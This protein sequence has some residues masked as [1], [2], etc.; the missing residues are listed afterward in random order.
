MMVIQSSARYTLAK[1]ALEDMIRELPRPDGSSPNK[2]PAEEELCRRLGVS[3]ATVREALRMLEREGIIS[4][5]HGSGNYYHS[6]ALDLSMRIDTIIDFTELLKDG[7]YQVEQRCA[8]Q[9][10]RPASPEERGMF[11]LQGEFLTYDWL[12]LAN[13]EVAILTTNLVPP[14]LMPR[15]NQNRNHSGHVDSNVMQLIWRLTGETVAHANVAIQARLADKKEREAFGLK[16]PAPIMGWNQIF[17]SFRDLP[18]AYVKVAF[19]PRIVRMQ[20]LQKWS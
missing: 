8:E 17:Y 15:E 9:C 16:A 7:G 13:G 4:K 11:K 20:M 18:V 5:R 1:K 14:D 19:N 6:S 2:L 10:Y 12:Y 3:L